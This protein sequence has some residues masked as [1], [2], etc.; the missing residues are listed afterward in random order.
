VFKESD[1]EKLAVS[2]EMLNQLQ[3]GLNTNHYFGS[4]KKKQT[5][6]FQ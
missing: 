3:K 6:R 2:V 5:L 1:T 4:T